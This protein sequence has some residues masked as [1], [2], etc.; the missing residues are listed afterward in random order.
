MDI[1]KRIRIRRRKKPKKEK[2]VVKPQV[3]ET[4][5]DQTEAPNT[6][7]Y[8]KESIK[9]E[10]LK[11]I[12]KHPEMYIE[13]NM[14]KKIRIV[15]NFFIKADTK[16]FEYKEKKYTINEERIYLLPTKSGYVMPTAF[17]FEGKD[18][19]TSFKQLNTG[20]TGKAL[21]LLYDENLYIDLFSVDVSKY[22]FII[23][24]LLIIGLCAYAGGMYVYFSL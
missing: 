14:V 20:I 8:C 11:D 5:Q 18:E 22:N 23:V 1:M 21:S 9:K 15:D 2:T 16:T 4:I 3:F 17:Y 24:I 12:N 6:S 19:P 7:I 10:G 13:I